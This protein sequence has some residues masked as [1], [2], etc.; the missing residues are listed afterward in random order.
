[1]A[2]KGTKRKTGK[3]KSQAKKESYIKD[4]IIILSTLAISILMMI[5]NFG[6]AGFVGKEISSFLIGVF[7]WI[8]YLIPVILFIVLLLSFQIKKIQSLI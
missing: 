6:L 5:S 4:E 2:S 1:M 8:G 7:G 3:K